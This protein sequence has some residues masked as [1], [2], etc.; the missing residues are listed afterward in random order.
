MKICEKTVLSKRI[1]D[2]KVIKVDVDDVELAD[3]KM[4]KREIVRHGGG[5]AI[6]FVRDGKVAMV[7]QF[8]YAY[9]KP[10]LEIP[11]GKVEPGED[12][13]HTAERELREEIGYAA[14]V[15]RLYLT[16][17]PSPGYTDEIIRV[18]IVEDAE[19]KV[20]TPDE[21][22]FLDIKFIKLSVVLKM[23]E[24]GK[25]TDSKTV[26]AVLKYAY[27]NAAG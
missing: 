6:L 21:G 2:G 14:K 1:Y 8:R 13:L 25:I 16:L 24:E 11:A 15:M 10:L 9:G 7:E 17:F 18:Y 3:G 5:A 27:E 26:G 22:E 23:I 12:P 19:K 4:T 20:A